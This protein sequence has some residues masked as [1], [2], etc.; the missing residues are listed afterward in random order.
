M[1]SQDRHASPKHS[2]GQ[3]RQGRLNLARVVLKLFFTVAFTEFLYTPFT[4]NKGR[5]PRV[6]RMTRRADV[7]M[8]FLDRGHRLND[9]ATG[10]R[11]GRYLVV[12]MDFFLHGATPARAFFRPGRYM[13]SPPVASIF[14]TCPLFRLATHESSRIVGYE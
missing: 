13:R 11:N 10:T 7:H 8:H 3:I 6:E 2:T 12:R 9:I 14:S 4:I 5:L 1:A